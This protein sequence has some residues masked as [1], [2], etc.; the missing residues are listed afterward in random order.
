MHAMQQGLTSE[1]INA[2]VD[3]IALLRIYWDGILSAPQDNCITHQL[4]TII[5]TILMQL[6]QSQISDLKA[7]AYKAHRTFDNINNEIRSQLQAFKR[8]IFNGD[9]HHLSEHEFAFAFDDFFYTLDTFQISISHKN[10]FFLKFCQQLMC[11]PEEPLHAEL[12]TWSNKYFRTP[13]LFGHEETLKTT[14]K[15]LYDELLINF[16]IEKAITHR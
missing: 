7:M 14:K 16:K 9:F 15:L 12:L 6:P 3:F 5:G 10:Q 8:K 13:R 2:R 1:D 11:R 4:F